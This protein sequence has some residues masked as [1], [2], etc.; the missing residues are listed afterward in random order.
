M[1]MGVKT[2][3]APVAVTSSRDVRCPSWKIHTMAPNVAVRL[4]TFIMMALIGTTTLPSMANNRT[5]VAT[6]MS[7]SA[8]GSRAV[9]ASL[10]STNRADGPVTTVGWSTSSWRM[11]RTMASLSGETASADGRTENHAGP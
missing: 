9:T 7:A 6:P 11:A 2:S 3:I 10:V 4:S 5:K 1:R 8:T